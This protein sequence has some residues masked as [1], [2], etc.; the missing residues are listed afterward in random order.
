MT[1]MQPGRCEPRGQ[2]IVLFALV[3][4][5]HR[6]RRRPRRSTAATPSSS[7]AAR[8]T[9]P[10]SRPS[11]AL[12][13]SPSGSMGTRPTAPM[14]TSRPPSPMPIAANG[15]RH[16]RRSARPDGPRYVD[17]NGG[18]PRLRRDRR[19]PGRQRSASRST[20]RSAA[21]A[22]TSSAS[23]GCD[24]LDRHD[25][26]DR[27]GRLRAAGPP[28]GTL[29]PAGISLA[30]FQT[31]PFCDGADQHQPVDA[32]LSAAPH[33]R[34]PQR[35]GRLRLAQVRLRRVRPR[36]GPGQHRRLREQQAVPRR[37]RS[38][39][40]ATATAAARRSACRAAPTRSAAC[41][42]TRP[43]PTA[44]TTST[45]RSRSPSRSGTTAGGTGSNAW[46][47]IVGFAGFQITGCSGGK[48]IEGVWRK[49]FFHGPASARRRPVPQASTLRS[50]ARQ[51]TVTTPLRAA[52]GRVRGRGPFL[53]P[54]RS[55]ARSVE[56]VGLRPAVGE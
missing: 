31:Y 42:A 3:L 54:V 4:D 29:F 40:P 36:P 50:P 13:S 20:S 38:A 47:H 2:I 26:R 32:V 43:A 45:T 14:P 23:S 34:Q 28:P 19:D 7:D 30:F 21:G 8:R 33:A 37:T 16:A 10:T 1:P 55:G 48:D 46:Y 22:R 6:P 11:P 52:T 12:A 39:R 24:E 51:V 27:Q 53:C 49:A 44:R 56:P 18:A 25:R 35:P 41:P 17:S 15:G 5:R 9:R